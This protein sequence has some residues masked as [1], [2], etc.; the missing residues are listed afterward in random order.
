MF[1][2]W[3]C[4]VFSTV[5]THVQVLLCISL[6]TP[7]KPRTK[8]KTKQKSSSPFSRFSLT[9]LTLHCCHKPDICHEK[10][11]ACLA[12]KWSKCFRSDD[13]AKKKKVLVC[14]RMT[15]VETHIQACWTTSFQRCSTVHIIPC[16][17]YLKFPLSF[18]LFVLVV[19]WDDTSG[20]INH[21]QQNR[22]HILKAPGFRNSSRHEEK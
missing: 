19:T 5:R 1:Y 9:S 21:N 4:T 14:A 3:H 6:Y 11:K 22:W 10:A 7:K 12:G 17:I 13:N 15:A 2:K 20:L 18:F 16:F 8:A